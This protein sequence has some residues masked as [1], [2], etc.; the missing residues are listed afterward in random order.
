MLNSMFRNIPSGLGSKG[1]L[2][3]SYS[4]LDKVLDNGLNW[5]LNNDYAIEEDLK[6]CEENGC[7]KKADSSLVS[8]KAK[9]RAIKQLGSLGS[10]NHFLEIQRIDEIYNK[11]IANKL[12]FFDKNQITVMVHTGSRALGHGGVQRESRSRCTFL[13]DQHSR[14]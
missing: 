10:G 1:K 9:Q 13:P 8:D 4:D 11:E 7:L 3:L 6:H 2:N 12:G 5:A 14:S